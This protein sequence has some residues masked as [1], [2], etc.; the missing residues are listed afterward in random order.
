M[1]VS[2]LKEQLDQALNQGLLP[3]T[4]VVISLE[5]WYTLI[6][7]QV[8]HPLNSEMDMW[9]T[10]SPAFHEDGTHQ[11]ADARFTPGHEELPNPT[12]FAEYEADQAEFT[13][14]E[15]GLYDPDYQRPH[16]FEWLEERFEG[17]AG[18][19]R[20]DPPKPGNNAEL[21]DIYHG[22]ATLLKEIERMS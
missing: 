2:E 13:D 6:D 7:I 9:F 8:E 12:F 21:A 15:S 22:L 19:L 3:T 18:A 4:E 20:D 10:L 17:L 14:P 16:Y 5:G 1:N 11:Q